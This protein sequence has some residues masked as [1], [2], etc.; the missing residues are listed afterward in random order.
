VL[1]NG[2]VRSYSTQQRRQSQLFALQEKIT[3]AFLENILSPKGKIIQ[4]TGEYGRVIEE[5]D[6]ME[7]K[8]TPL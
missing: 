7:K 4:N 2:E 1:N 8:S 6:A 5:T 3:N